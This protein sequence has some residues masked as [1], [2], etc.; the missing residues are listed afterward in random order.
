MT[1]AN[2][3]SD[4]RPVINCRTT[5]RAR[6][7]IR[8]PGR[9]R[10]FFCRATSDAL[11]DP[12]RRAHVV[13]D[14]IVVTSAGRA[15]APSTG[16]CCRTHRVQ[17]GRRLIIKHD[18]RFV[19]MARASP[20]RLRMPPDSSA[21]CLFFRAGQITI[22]SA[23]ATRR[24]ISARSD[25]HAGATRTPHFPQP[26]SNRTAR[27]LNTMPNFRRTRSNWR[28]FIGTMFRRQSAPRPRPPQQADEKLSKTLLPTRC[29]R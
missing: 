22:S 13:R 7:K 10:K 16:Q 19:M 8:P 4:R 26:S 5:G 28:S 14:T 24:A 2:V 17:T 12:P 11:A 20:T 29:A 1:K 9:S 21:D 25:V 18:L 6:Q 27:A 15:P 3:P 23:P